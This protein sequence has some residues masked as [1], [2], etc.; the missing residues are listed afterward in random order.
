MSFLK[1]ANVINKNPS[2]THTVC[3]HCNERFSAIFDYT[4][5]SYRACMS[6]IKDSG[7]S[8]KTKNV[9]NVMPA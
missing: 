3:D 9:C 4:C 5:L 6:S 8:A 1:E 7:T 2:G